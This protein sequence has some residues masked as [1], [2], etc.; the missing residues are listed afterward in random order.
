MLNERPAHAFVYDAASNVARLEVGAA[1]GTR[2]TIDAQLLLDAHGFL[3]GVDLPEGSRTVVMLGPHEKVDRTLSARV[4]V[5]YDASGQPARV[6]VGDA[7]KAIRAS[8]KNP[9]AR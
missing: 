5:T 1:E 3:V 8:E 4:S 6:E 7:R 9:Y 2:K